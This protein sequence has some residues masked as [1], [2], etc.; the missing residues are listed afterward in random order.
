PVDARDLGSMYNLDTQ[1]FVRPGRDGYSR[2]IVKGDHN[3]WGPRL[4]LAYRLAP[5][6]VVRTAYGLFYGP[7]DY[8]D[9][10]T[11]IFVAPPY[12]PSLANPSATVSGTVT[13]S[14]TL[15]TPIK[16]LPSDPTLSAFSA[17]NP[18]SITMQTNDFFNNPNPYVQQWNFTLQYELG[19][20][21]LFEASY[22]GA[23]G[24]KLGTRNNLNQVPFEYA[25]D[26]RN[27]QAYRRMPKIN[28]TGGYS[29]ADGN[30]IYNATNIRVEKR[31]AQGLNFLINY[32]IAK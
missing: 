9:G 1:Q 12:T 3:N 5:H 18:S 17:A 27:T 23:K 20:T 21:W 7:R 15:N 10:T 22:T 31:F 28:G 24:T 11:S 32:T 13:P 29:A 30:N 16:L 6:L 25:L 2:A 19:R 4:G 26:G 14:F 8:N